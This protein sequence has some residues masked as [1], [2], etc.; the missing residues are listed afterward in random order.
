MEEAALGGLSTMSS[1]GVTESR[2]RGAGV[3][4]AAVGSG[5]YK[6]V[7]ARLKRPV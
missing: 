4:C 5:F 1:H 6:P 3:S 2:G 7:V